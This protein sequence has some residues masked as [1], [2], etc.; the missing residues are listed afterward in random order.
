MPCPMLV[1]LSTSRDDLRCEV[2]H[3]FDGRGR[4]LQRRA[5]EADFVMQN[6]LPVEGFGPVDGNT[7]RRKIEEKYLFLKLSKKLNSSFLNG[8]QASPKR[9]TYPAP[10]DKLCYRHCRS[11]CLF[12]MPS[13]ARSWKVLAVILSN[14]CS[15][16]FTRL[17]VLLHLLPSCACL[18]KSDEVCHTE[19]NGTCAFT[20]HVLF[21]FATSP[22]VFQGGLG[23][24]E[25]Q[26]FCS[27][28]VVALCVWIH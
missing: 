23:F 27:R 6:T 18:V 9:L 16:N 21:P 5:F 2:S 7:M 26:M 28:M 13:C 19:G 25:G 10:R 15:W 1:V 3:D 14:A 20:R 17:F 12:V 24:G 22:V 4:M 11:R 8:G